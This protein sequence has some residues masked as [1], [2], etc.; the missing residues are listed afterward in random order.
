MSLYRK[1]NF[2]IFMDCLS[3]TFQRI[4][5]MVFVILMIVFI[6]W[7][8]SGCASHQS[9]TFRVDHVGGD[10]W[11]RDIASDA[12]MPSEGTGF[13]GE[14]EMPA[15]GI[16]DIGINYIGRGLFASHDVIIGSVSGSLF[17][18]RALS[19]TQNVDIPASLEK[20]FIPGDPF[21]V[22]GSGNELERN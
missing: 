21:A 18:D 3:D 20:L 15:A 17:I 7:M 6:A 4:A 2:E 9:K 5:G 8:L 1:S 14:T 12:Q 10:L 11:I 16:P 22:T 13:Q 19:G